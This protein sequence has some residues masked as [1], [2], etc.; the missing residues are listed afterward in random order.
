MF[1]QPVENGVGKTTAHQMAAAYASTH[2]ESM[3]RL[4]IDS[5]PHVHRMSGI[6]CTI[7]E[8]ALNIKSVYM[9]DRNSGQKVNGPG[10]G[11]TF[12]IGQGTIKN[13]VTS[14]KKNCRSSLP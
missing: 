7:G 11:K 4:D 3:C 1:F 14:T 6:I 13:K 9:Y 10:K 12:E 2:L 8:F 5:E